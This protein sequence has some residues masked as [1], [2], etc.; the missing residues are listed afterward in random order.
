[1]FFKYYKKILYIL[2]FFILSVFALPFYQRSGSAFLPSIARHSGE[3]EYFLVKRVVDGD[4]IL[5]DNGERV[6]YIGMDTPESVKPDSPVE[7]FGKEASER[8]KELVLGKTVRLKKD[9]SEKDAYGRLL[10]YVYID[11]TFVNL[12]LVDEGYAKA[13]TK[14]P[15]VKYSGIFKEAERKAKEKKLNMWGACMH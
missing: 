5:L 1:M 7:C 11:D 3:V 14:K 12:E 8:N 9:V 6:R 10:R 15:D 13:Y 2:P 4:T